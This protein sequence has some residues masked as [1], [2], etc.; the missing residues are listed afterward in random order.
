MQAMGDNQIRVISIYIISI[1]YYSLCC[2]YLEYFCLAISKIESCCL[3]P[4]EV[5]RKTDTFILSIVFSC[6][7]TNLFLFS[8]PTPSAGCKIM[9][10]TL[11]ASM[12]SSYSD[13]ACTIIC[14]LFE[15]DLF[16]LTSCP[17]LCMLL[18]VIGFYPCFKLICH[19]ILHMCHSFPIHSSVDRHLV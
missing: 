7:V 12:R 3:Q 2:R 19:S 4:S 16:H 14:C 9:T 8:F 15:I 1:I 11:F 17:P 10:L 5:R 13:S 18:P 6:A